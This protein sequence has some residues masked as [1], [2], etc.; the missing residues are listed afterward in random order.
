MKFPKFLA[1]GAIV[2]A[3]STA[4]AEQP[5]APYAGFE[6]RALKALS[7]QEISDLADGKGMGMA[8]AAELNGYPGPRHVLD[9]APRIGLSP[10]LVSETETLFARM[11]ASAREIGK[12]VL[13]AEGEL[14]KRFRN[15]SIDP[16]ALRALTS[17][18]GALR[19]ELRALHLGYHL[20]M[21]ALLNSDQIARYNRLRGYG[22]SR[23]G[24]TGGHSHN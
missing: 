22:Q 15:R 1:A 19:S 16:D 18:I 8:L 23:H 14:E 17:E 9:L 3:A 2:A 6:T 4:G 20:K 21:R 5:H 7:S 12:H 11:Q 24:T 10:N 13:E